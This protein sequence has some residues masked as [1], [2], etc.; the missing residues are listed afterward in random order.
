[1]TSIG[2][3]AAIFD[4]DGRIL[5]VKRNYGPRNWTTPGGKLEERESPLDGMVRE[6]EEE[7]GYLVE[8]GPLVGVYAAPF[9]DDI[10]L[11]FEAAATGC[12]TWTADGEISEIAYF[13]E[14]SLPDMRART[15]VRV[16]DAFAGKRGVVRVFP[17]EDGG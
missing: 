9:K 17:G 10:V 4:D 7:T 16:R 5:L 13:A 11:F 1:M 15:L 6:V 3:F 8:A 2:V 12:G 14:D